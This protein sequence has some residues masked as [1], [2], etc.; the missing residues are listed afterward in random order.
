MGISSVA[1]DVIVDAEIFVLAS[2]FLVL[3][4][5]L[6]VWLCHGPKVHKTD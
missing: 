4:S 6:H 5:V 3:I 1:T 2:H